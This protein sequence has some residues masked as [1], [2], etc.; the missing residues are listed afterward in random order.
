MSTELD[1]GEFHALTELEELRRSNTE[2]Q[3]RLRRSKAK[4]DD[5]VAAATWP[6]VSS[7]FPAQPFEIDQTLFGQYVAVSRLIV[8][9]IRRALGIYERVSVVAEWGNHGRVGSK[10]AA[11]PRSD[12]FDRMAYELARQILV[13]EQRLDWDSDSPEDIQRVEVGNY[14][15]LLIHGDEVGRNGYASPMTIVSHVA[16][17]QSGAYPWSFTDCHLGH[18][19]THAEWPLPN[20]RGSVYQTGSPE[21]D[22][23]YAGVMLAGQALPSQRLHFID[24]EAGR[25]TSV[26]KVWL[27]P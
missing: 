6:R 11:V 15:A 17:W 13:G 8:D 19:H 12:N 4:V 22:N 26:H 27:A 3:V 10:R 23:R 25:V 5:L 9:I 24:P 7:S 18:Y 21:S 20:G 2:L 1:L 14:R 16:R